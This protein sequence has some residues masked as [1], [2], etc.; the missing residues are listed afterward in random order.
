[1]FLYI[2]Q[3]TCCDINTNPRF[4]FELYL[5]SSMIST[6]NSFPLHLEQL[7][8]QQERISCQDMKLLGRSVNYINPY[9]PYATIQQPDMTISAVRLSYDT[10]IR[11][12]KS[13]SRYS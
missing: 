6:R 2:P 4:Y 11:K 3:A 9:Q 13:S 1:M 12:K 7:V 8:Q 10:G 5:I